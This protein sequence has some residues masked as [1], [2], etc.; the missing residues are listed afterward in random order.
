V[1]EPTSFSSKMPVART[2]PTTG[3]FRLAISDSLETGGF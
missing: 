2:F 3:A 1:L